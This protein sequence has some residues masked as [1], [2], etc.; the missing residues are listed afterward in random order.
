MDPAVAEL[1]TTVVGAF[2]STPLPPRRFARETDMEAVLLPAMKRALAPSGIELVHSGV[3]RVPCFIPDETRE[4][5]G[6][7]RRGRLAV[8]IEL[9]LLRG[10]RADGGEF[11]RGF[12]QCFA[13][14]ALPLFSA[15]LLLVVHQCAERSLSVPAEMLGLRTEPFRSVIIADRWHQAPPQ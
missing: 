3:R 9:K 2:R 1:A 12:G 6:E 14:V 7:A 8:A 13:Y 15:A 4:P 5:D 11:H 10:E